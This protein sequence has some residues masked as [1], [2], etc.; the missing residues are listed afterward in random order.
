MK[1]FFAHL[2]LL[3]VVVYYALPYFIE[4]IT[5]SDYRSAIIAAILFAFIN[6][7]I[8]PVINL[9]TLPLNLLTLGLFGLVVN[10]LLFWF[11]SSIITGFSVATITAAILGALVMTV[12]NWIIEKVLH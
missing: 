1:K 4:G 5:L 12:A 6:I 10:V 7:A 11:V 9:I 3:A 8:K 2:I